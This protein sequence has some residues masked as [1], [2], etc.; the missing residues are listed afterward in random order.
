M[1]ETRFDA[2]TRRRFGL[3]AGGFAGSLLS[4]VH[5]G[6]GEAKVS[7]KAKKRCKKDSNL[8]K[9]DATAYCNSRYSSPQKE[10][11][12][13]DIHHCC[14]FYAKCSKKNNQKGN[15]CNEAIPW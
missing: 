8:C 14:S 11:C 13:T 12:I 3:A 5:F 6:S 9:S 7:K 15:A 4:L 2:M 10:Q 1:S